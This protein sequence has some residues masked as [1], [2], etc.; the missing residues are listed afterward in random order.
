[1][2][3]FA[4]TPALDK[5]QSSIQFNSKW[6]LQLI[7]G[8]SSN[9]QNLLKYFNGKT[10]FVSFTKLFPPATPAVFPT[11]APFYLNDSELSAI[12]QHHQLELYFF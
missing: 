5:I 9:L 3:D 7:N 1:M 11:G 6:I 8:I 2:L 12:I 10:I 4:E